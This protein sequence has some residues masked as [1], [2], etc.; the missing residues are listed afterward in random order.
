MSVPT[1]NQFG[2]DDPQLL[3]FAISCDYELFFALAMARELKQRS[4][5]PI[6]NAEGLAPLFRAYQGELKSPGVLVKEADV[7]HIPRTLYPIVDALDFVKKIRLVVGSVHRKTLAGRREEVKRNAPR[8]ETGAIIWR[9]VG[10]PAEG[11]R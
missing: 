10:R 8:D 11:G 2:L 1:L 7:A 3:Q 9:R 4:M 5:F 6:A